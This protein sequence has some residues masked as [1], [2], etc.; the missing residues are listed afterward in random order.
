M[1]ASNG[2][3][4]S[5]VA[6]DPYAIGYVG[7]A[8][9]NRTVAGIRIDKK[10]PTKYNALHGIYPHV[11]YLYFVNYAAHPMNAEAQ[12]FVNYTRSSAGQ[13]IAAKE[14]LPL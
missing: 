8:F 11:R 9:V 2:M 5:A 4:R 13:K 6:R 10:A 1:Y 7:M 14:Y 12:A 3:V